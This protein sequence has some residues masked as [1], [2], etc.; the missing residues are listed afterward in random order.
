MRRLLCANLKRLKKDKVYWAGNIFLY[1]FSAFVCMVQMRNMRQLNTHYTMDY[2]LF[3]SFMAVGIVLSVVISL[4]VGTEYSDGTIRNKVIVGKSRS[5]I[6]LANSITCSIVAAGS[7]LTVTVFTL[8]IGLP[9]FGWVEMGVSNLLL[10]MLIYVM[11]VI[12][13]ASIYSLTAMLC[14]NKAYASIINVLLAFGLEFAAIYLQQRLAAQEMM[15]QVK[16]AM[17][18]EVI[19]EEIRNPGYLTGVTREIYQFFMDILPSGQAMEVACLEVI[20][21][22]RLLLC[23]VVIIL[24]FNTVGI[25]V[26]NKKDLK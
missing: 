10:M 17:N 11:A 18:G 23:S 5:D 6:Y 12:A 14:S 13:Y 7:A 26:F 2:F 25:F 24:F 9:I 1:G 4:F 8:L 15:T 3:A 19:Y 22:V 21:P 20:H 16:V